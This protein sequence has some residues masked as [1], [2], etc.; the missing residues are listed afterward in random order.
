MKNVLR[1]SLIF[2]SVLSCTSNGDTSIPA[3]T[4]TSNENS[5]PSNQW[6]LI[7]SDEFSGSKID[8]TKWTFLKNC[9]GGG[10]D[11]LQCYTDRTKNAVV[12]NGQL[13][14]IARKESIHGQDKDDEDPNYNVND[15]SATRSYSSARLRTKTKGDWKYGRMEIK[16]KMP[17]GQGIWPAIWMMPSEWKYGF[18]PRSGEIDIFEAVNS[19][20]GIFG[21]KIHGTLHYGDFPPKNNLSGTEYTPAT[22]I[23]D[24]FHR[25]SVEWEEGEI[26]WYVDNVHFA[27]QT[28]DAWFTLYDDNGKTIRSQKTEPFDQKFHL[29]LNLAVGGEWPKAPTSATH[30]PQQM[31]VDYVRVYRCN[32]DLTTG[33]GCATNINPEIKPNTPTTVKSE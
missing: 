1:S 19:N 28:K 13:H 7:W 6:E 18:W 9:F 5:V 29:I 17:Q 31:D 26:R 11:E 20:T 22:N 15:T 8:T 14:I 16:A 33:K 21:N 4:S 2:L 12:K 24:N 32:V 30:F 25:Y 27:T 23:W 3:N 10:N